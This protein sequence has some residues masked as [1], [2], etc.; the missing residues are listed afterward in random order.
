MA[1]LR[2]YSPGVDSALN[3]E[4]C[5]RLRPAMVIEHYSR[6][7]DGQKSLCP[8]CAARA[9]EEHPDLLASAVVDLILG[10]GREM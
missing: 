4:G 5:F 3:C 6:F 8:Q 7:R 1:T 2:R 9:L 10:R